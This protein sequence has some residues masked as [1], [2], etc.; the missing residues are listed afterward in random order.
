ML[1]KFISRK[2]LKN[3]QLNNRNK[4][5]CIAR[6]PSILLLVKKTF[7]YYYRF[8]INSFSVPISLSISVQLN[9]YLSLI[10]S[11]LFF[12]F[13]SYIIRD[14]W[15]VTI[16]LLITQES[17]YTFYSNRILQNFCRL[18]NFYFKFTKLN[19]T[20]KSYVNFFSIFRVF[21]IKLLLANGDKKILDQMLLNLTV[22]LKKRSSFIFVLKKF[23]IKRK[24]STT[25]YH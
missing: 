18:K 24:T 10:I 3:N 20:H 19:V 22:V 8:F 2:K 4:L 14:E 9:I 15:M 1:S 5:A 16:L 21:I 17:F 23:A 6:S 7:N 11:F 25:I 13:I 12:F